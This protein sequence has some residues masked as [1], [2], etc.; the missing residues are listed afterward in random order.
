MPALLLLKKLTKAYPCNWYFRQ[1]KKSGLIILF[2]KKN[3]ALNKTYPY[4]ASDSLYNSLSEHVASEVIYTE[5]GK[6]FQRWLL[7]EFFGLP[8]YQRVSLRLQLPD[9]LMVDFTN[10]GLYDDYITLADYRYGN[11]YV[12]NKKDFKLLSVYDDNDLEAMPIIEK[13]KP[14]AIALFKNATEDDIKFYKSIKGDKIGL[15]NTS[16]LHGDGYYVPAEINFPNHRDTMIIISRFGGLL[17]IKNTEKPL[18]IPPINLPPRTHMSSGILYAT[19]KKI[20]AEVVT[21]KELQYFLAEF[22]H[23]QEDSLRFVRFY[24]FTKSKLYT[25]KVKRYKASY[26]MAYPYVFSQLGNEVW[27]VETEETL[28]LPFKENNVSHDM[29]KQNNWLTYDYMFLDGILMSGNI[30]RLLVDNGNKQYSITDV[31][32]NKM[33]LINT[34]KIELPDKTQSQFHFFDSNTILYVKD[35]GIYTVTI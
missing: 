5:N 7:K 26:Y 22:S 4:I 13:I 27:N 11:I 12:I 30:L 34:I 24:P 21:G 23:K 20:I 32:M 2:I 29:K 16:S 1:L 28:Q 6:V 25:E 17:S 14:E 15:L 18:F 10:I 35:E 19:N 33:E 3:N 31:D 9:S 8:T